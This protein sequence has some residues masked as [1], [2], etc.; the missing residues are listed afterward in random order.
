MH[1]SQLFDEGQAYAQST[2]I[3]STSAFGLTEHIEDL[4]QEIR[5][6]TPTSVCHINACKP[7]FARQR[8]AY[9]AASWRKLERIAHHVPQ[10]LFKTHGIGLNDQWG[11]DAGHQKINAV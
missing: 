2:A 6:D 3:P 4:G 10:H 1:F 9:A 11:V 8:E 5:M 7:I